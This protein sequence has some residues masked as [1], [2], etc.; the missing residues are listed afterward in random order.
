MRYLAFLL[1]A[2]VLAGCSGNPPPTLGPSTGPD[3]LA[4]P[5]SEVP[6]RP[7]MAGTAFHGIGSKP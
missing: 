5:P 6:Y 2:I 4:A 1:A 3:G 7:V